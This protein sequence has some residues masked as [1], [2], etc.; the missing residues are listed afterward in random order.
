VLCGHGDE[1]WTSA[2]Y[3]RGWAGFYEPETLPLFY[4][5]ATR[6]RVVVDVGASIGIFT[7]VAGHANPSGSVIAVEPSAAFDRLVVNVRANGLGNVTALRVAAGSDVGEAQLYSGAVADPRLALSILASSSLRREYVDDLAAS[8]PVRVVDLERLLREQGVQRVDLLKLDTEGTEVDVL[9]GMRA[10]IER[11]RPTIVCEVL[12]RKAGL[13]LEHFLRPLGYRWYHL[14][15]AGP[16]ERDEIA[17]APGRAW[18]NHLFT[19]LCPEELAALVQE[20]TAVDP[21]T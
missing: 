7:L 1:P 4:A 10:T 8:H 18:P 11:D 13:A 19:D 5:F 16:L 9:E 12:D 15:W 21:T 20:H 3:W 6:A 2:L 14:T 17:P